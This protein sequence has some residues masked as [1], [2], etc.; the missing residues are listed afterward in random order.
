MEYEQLPDIEERNGGTA[1][2]LDPMHHVDLASIS[3]QRAIPGWD[4]TSR[5]T[6]PQKAGEG[7]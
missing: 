7:R 1:I 4:A 6:D 5:D 3:F 2:C